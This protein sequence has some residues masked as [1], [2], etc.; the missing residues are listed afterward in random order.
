MLLYKEREII[1]GRKQ[2]K[3]HQNKMVKRN[4]ISKFNLPI[5]LKT[6]FSIYV[7]NF[8]NDLTNNQFNQ[9]FGIDRELSYSRF[10]R[11]CY[12]G[13]S[14]RWIE[15]RFAVICSHQIRSKIDF[16]RMMHFGRFYFSKD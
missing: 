13:H 1:S 10:G 15:K 5:I 14:F 4:K 9:F 3:K 8:V 12:L 11:I 2:G 16:G 7:P 6:N